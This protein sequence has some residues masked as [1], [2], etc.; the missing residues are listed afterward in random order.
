M[1]V[2]VL[3]VCL[4]VL[5]VCCFVFVFYSTVFTYVRAL[6]NPISVFGQTLLGVHIVCGNGSGYLEGGSSME[7]ECFI[8]LI[9]PIKCFTE[10]G[11]TWAARVI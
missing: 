8:L 3:F 11:T 5:C 1:F 6:I 4:F 9:A 2:L 10:H 7:N